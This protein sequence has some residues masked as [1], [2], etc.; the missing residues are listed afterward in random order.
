MA[1]WLGRHGAIAA[2]RAGHDV[3]SCPFTDLYLDFRQSDRLDEPI[4][5][6]NVTAVEDVYT[7]EPVPPELAAADAARVIG[8]QANIWTEHIDSVRSLDYMAFPRLSAAAEIA[9][10]SADR[11]LPD[12][13]ARLEHHEA[14]LA[15]LGVE[16]R[17]R[18][19]PRPWQTRPGVQGRPRD[20]ADVEA[21]VANLASGFRV[22]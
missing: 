3:V 11:D 1:G 16:Y 15:A 19:G 7:F 9:W 8:V 13:M 2:A 14:R 12:F 18:S 17:G 5:I 10:C 4:P 22:D 6:G 20:R 21:D